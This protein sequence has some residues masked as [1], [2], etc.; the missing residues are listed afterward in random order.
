MTAL[1]GAAYTNIRGKIL[2]ELLEAIGAKCVNNGTATYSA[3]GHNSIIDLVIIDSRIRTDSIDFAVLNEETPSDHRAILVTLREY[4]PGRRQLNI[5]S[6]MTE[7]QIHR[8]TNNAANRIKNCPQITPEA[9]Q[10]IIKEEIPKIPPSNNKY[11]PIYWWSAEIEEQRRIMQRYKRV[12][13]KLRARNRTE[14]EGRLAI[15]QYR[16]AW[17]ILNFLIKQVKKKKWL[18]LCEELNVDPWGK[19]FKIVT[20]SLGRYVP[21]LSAEMSAQQVKLLFPRI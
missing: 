17:K 9:F 3:R 6:R 1:A 13:Q 10:D 14:E 5:F 21:T 12:D 4:L 7:Q 8:V 2:E 18:E 11:H 20:K 19:A 15:E 16:Q